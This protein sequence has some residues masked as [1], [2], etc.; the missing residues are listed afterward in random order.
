MT[1]TTYIYINKEVAQ[2]TGAVSV[3]SHELLHGILN[4]ELKGKI[5][6]E[7]FSDWKFGLYRISFNYEIN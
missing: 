1:K 3:G 4:K 5:K 6:Y 7:N 2:E